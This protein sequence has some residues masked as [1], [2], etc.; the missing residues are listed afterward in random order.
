MDNMDGV[1]R[2][3]VHRVSTFSP[4]DLGPASPYYQQVEQLYD[5]VQDTQL[6]DELMMSLDH[7]DF[8]DEGLDEYQRWEEMAMSIFGDRLEML[9]DII[10]SEPQV[11]PQMPPAP[12]PMRVYNR[13][14]ERT[15]VDV[16]SGD[17]KNLSKAKTSCVATDIMPVENIHMPVKQ[18]DATTPDIVKEAMSNNAILTSYN[19]LT[20]LKSLD[21]V[22]EVDG[23]H[24]YPDTEYIRH[25]MKAELDTDGGVEVL[26]HKFTDYVHDDLERGDEVCPGYKCKTFYAPRKIRLKK[27]S[28]INS[29]GFK[30][31]IRDLDYRPCGKTTPKY[32]GLC[33][34][35]DGYSKRLVTRDGIGVRLDH[36]LDFVLHLE[37]LPKHGK[38]EA[39]VLLRV[40]EYRGFVPFHGLG[41]LESFCQSVDLRIDDVKVHPPGSEAL[42]CYPVDGVIARHNDVDYRWKT[43][44]TVEV[45]NIER[46]S[47]AI[48]KLG[49]EPVFLT[50]GSGLCEYKVWARKDAI[51]FDLVGPRRDKTEETDPAVI[52]RYA[53]FTGNVSSR[54]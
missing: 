11:E 39:Y 35:L 8:A 41:S 45:E 46:V 32:D 5:M 9:C 27:I 17:C 42:V 43:T 47:Q 13:V 22:K 12:S 36:E 10:D 37:K 25:E 34:M 21:C 40:L 26:R 4:N 44:Y 30:V 24:V 38:A 28:Y 54:E 29:T 33:L 49:H 14:G 6:L 3:G 20:Q 52:V 31:P 23:L 18:I 50:T 19:S 51:V 2:N 48:E 1:K 53:Y 15:I 16:G 7:F